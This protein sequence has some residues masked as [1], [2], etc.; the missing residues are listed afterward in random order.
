MWPAPAEQGHRSK[1]G[2]Y[3]GHP[4]RSRCE[5][6]AHCVLSTTRFPE[7]V[8]KTSLR[9][10]TEYSSREKTSPNSSPNC[11]PK[12]LQI[13]LSAPLY[14]ADNKSSPALTTALLTE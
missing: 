14:S 7:A 2:C 3:F 1:I 8:M 9:A 12:E 11:A 10:A 6:V 13:V 4:R 5:S